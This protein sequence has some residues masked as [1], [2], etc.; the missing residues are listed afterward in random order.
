VP[1]TFVVAA[2]SAGTAGTNDATASSTPAAEQIGSW[3]APDGSFTVPAC[4]LRPNAYETIEIA[5]PAQVRPPGGRTC[6]SS[7]IAEGSGRCGV[8]RYFQIALVGGGADDQDV[9]PRLLCHR[10]SR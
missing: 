7:F 10:F 3:T 8:L 9:A 5:A 6:I 1:R 2:A 4:D